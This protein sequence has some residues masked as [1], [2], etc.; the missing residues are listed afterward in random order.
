MKSK[1]YMENCEK[2]EDPV[3][4]LPLEV[5]TH[6]LS[7]LDAASLG[8]ACQVCRYLCP[9]L[10]FTSHPYKDLKSMEQYRLAESDVEKIPSPSPHLQERLANDIEDISIALPL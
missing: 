7:F 10:A 8:L 9:A 4:R 3:E 6:I 1:F 2:V 5:S